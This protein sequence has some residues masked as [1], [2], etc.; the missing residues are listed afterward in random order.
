MSR[1]RP[2]RYIPGV[3][4]E[5]KG[6]LPSTQNLGGPSDLRGGYCQLVVAGPGTLETVALP[7][8]GVLIIGRSERAQ[9]RIEDETVSGRHAA[10]HVDPERGFELEDL[11]SKNGTLVAGRRYRSDRTAIFPGETL[12]VGATVMLLQVWPRMS[13]TRRIWTHVYLRARLEEEALRALETRG[14]LSFV[15]V[16]LHGDGG[17]EAL[18]AASAG[19]LRPWDLMASYGSHDF[20][21]LL[22]GTAAVAAE[23]LAGELRSALERLGVTCRTGIASLRRDGET[24][25]A[26]L[27]RAS[28]ALHGE[29][30]TA[31][32]DGQTQALVLDEQM[33]EIYAM[34]E[35][36]AASESVVLLTG[37]TGVGKDLLAR[38]IHEHSR[39]RG[40]RFAHIDVPSLS[41]SLGEDELFGHARGAF[42]DAR[43]ARAGLLEAAA[44]GTVF[45]DEIGDLSPAMQ[46]KLLR[47]LQ[48]RVVR[49]IG[50]QN[51]RQLDVRF[52]AATNRDLGAAIRD[53]TF[54]EDLYYRLRV[55]TLSVP[56]LR[57]RP[58]EIEPL[59]RLFVKRLSEREHRDRVPELSP[60]AVQTL[61][62]HTW[63]GNVRELFNVIERAVVLCAGEVILPRHLAD[64]LWPG[65]APVER[66][67]G[68]E[69]LVRRE[70]SEEPATA[71]RE[72]ED[73]EKARVLAALEAAHWRRAAAARILDMSRT[74]LYHRMKRYGLLDMSPDAG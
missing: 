40:G 19:V 35:K 14:D 1:K 12:Q 49:R 25:D 15:R 46:V 38:W 50:E 71:G 6:T 68:T 37:E 22:P 60:E 51:D 45:L 36:V 61:E 72:A 69:E 62:A 4:D 33:R 24:P 10:L 29:A 34:A 56:P 20:E 43:E 18:R 5:T 9:V 2:R 53:R 48:Y 42:T 7:E 52:I 26:L 65:V 55:F 47:V 54:R 41:E 32:A 66:T 27:F 67:S 59:A 3:P 30:G 64:V 63:P 57:E 28:Q 31:A 16:R 70:P 17:A 44:G 21:L 23:R 73:A 11:G 58:G 39:R 74:S 8:R 13:R